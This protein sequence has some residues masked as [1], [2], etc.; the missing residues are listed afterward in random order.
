M[1]R[2]FFLLLLALSIASC[3]PGFSLVLRN[4]LPVDKQVRVFVNDKNK[5]NYIDSIPITDSFSNIKIPVE[6][7]PTDFSYSF[8]LQKGKEAVIQ[9]GLGGPDW[10]QKMVIGNRD[11]LVLKTD[12]RVQVSR[13]HWSTHVL[14]E[15]K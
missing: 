9:S 15:L 10:T 1:L 6:K 3:D 14:I 13:K 11:T 12:K 4:R 2:L 7:S 5:F 8:V